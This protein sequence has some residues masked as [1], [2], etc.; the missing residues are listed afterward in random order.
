MPRQSLLCSVDIFEQSIIASTF[1]NKGRP[2]ASK[3]IDAVGLVN[4]V[5]TAIDNVTLWRRIDP[6]VVAIGTDGAGEQRTLIVRGAK[7]TTIRCDVGNRR[8]RITVMMPNLLAELAGD[9]NRFTRICRVLAFSGSLKKS[10]LLRLPPVPNMHSDGK[11]CMGSVQ[12]GQF[13]D[14]SAA[15]FFEKAFIESIFTDHL[16]HS[17]LGANSKYND[18]IG[19]AGK[20][21][22]RVPLKMLRKVGT[23]AEVYKELYNA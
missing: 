13:A 21:A 20:L 19:A 15:E 1:D 4:L 6:G 16:A 22:G 3:E 8:R 9:G 11:V 5:Q 23:A 14:L 12:A 17:P 18:I 10:T 7:K 2:R